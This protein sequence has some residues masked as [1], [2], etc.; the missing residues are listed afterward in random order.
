MSKLS[1]VIPVYYNEDSL[2]PLY[3]DIKEKVIPQLE[4]YEIIFVDDGSGDDSWKVINE[5]KNADKNVIGVKLS[6]NFGEHSALLAGLSVATGDC[7]ATKQADLQEDAGLILQMYESWKSGNKVVIAARQG[8]EDGAF[9]TF[10]A[11]IYYR[12]VKKHV[13]EKMPNGGFDCFLLDRQAVET[14]V[15]LNE[16]NSSLILQIL[17]IGYPSETIY[18][19][20]LEREIGQSRWTF[21]KKLKLVMDSFIGFSYIPIRLMWIIG[22]LFFVFAICMGISVM[23]EYFTVGTPIAGWSTLIC[24]V[25]LSAGLILWMLGVLGEYAW[26]SFD[27]ARRRPPF[28]IDEI[29]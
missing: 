25:L 8:R 17:W 23:V 16:T 20:R 13:T 5:L 24:V 9:A 21:T 14:L 7:V 15:K 27:A 12:L 26:R 18:Y 6:R 3:E 28:I 4:D 1:I 11:G 29:I 19:R 22:I 10:F 2:Q